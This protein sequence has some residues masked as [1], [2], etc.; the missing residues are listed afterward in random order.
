MYLYSFS[1]KQRTPSKLSE[2]SLESARHDLI[3]DRALGSSI[4]E[5][6]VISIGVWVGMR[7]TPEQEKIIQVI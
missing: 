4:I 3:W 2:G 5:H 1:R 6:G 7:L